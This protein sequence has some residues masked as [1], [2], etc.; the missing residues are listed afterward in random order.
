MSPRCHLPLVQVAQAWVANFDAV[1]PYKESRV[2]RTAFLGYASELDSSGR[3]RV[4]FLLQLQV[5]WVNH[6]VCTCVCAC[7]WPTP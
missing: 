4:P 5:L 7:V 3:S 1:D 2:L 6:Q